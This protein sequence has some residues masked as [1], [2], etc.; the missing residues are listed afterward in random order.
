M[1]ATTLSGQRGAKGEK[2]HFEGVQACR[3]CYES[4]AQLRGNVMWVQRGFGLGGSNLKL[5][6]EVPM[7]R[8]K[9]PMQRSGQMAVMA[10]MCGGECKDSR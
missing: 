1:S 3:P 4:T 5:A 2:Q 7:C 9:D 10:V 8:R 6:L